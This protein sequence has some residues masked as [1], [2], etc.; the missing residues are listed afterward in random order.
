MSIFQMVSCWKKIITK[1]KRT[2]HTESKMQYILPIK[3]KYEIQLV[4][5][6]STCV[7]FWYRWL[8][9]IHCELLS[10]DTLP[11]SRISAVANMQKGHGRQCCGNYSQILKFAR[12][13]NAH[14]TSASKFTKLEILTLIHLFYF[15]HVLTN[16]WIIRGKLR[17]L[18]LEWEWCGGLFGKFTM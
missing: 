8:I 12:R 4:N 15:P 9:R 1:K 6:L 18:D 5:W 11:Q 14:T 10:V 7:T 13:S 3:I 2:L 17:V 16:F